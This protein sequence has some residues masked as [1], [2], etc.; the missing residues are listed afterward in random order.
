MINLFILLVT[1]TALFLGVGW[2]IG[3]FIGITLALLI[4]LIINFLS[5]WYS[6]R[7]ILKIYNAIPTKHIQVQKMVEKFAREAKIP[8]PKLYLIPTRPDIM[9]AF[10]TGRDPAHSAIAVTRGLLTLEDDEIEAVIAHEMGHIRNR[11]TLVSTVAAVLAG[12]VS[13]LAQIGYWS[14]FMGGKREG[15]NIF[16]MFMIMFFAPLAAVMIKL[17]ITRQREYGAD[18]M[19]VVL[20]KN[21]KSLVSALTK[22]SNATRE[23]ILRGPSATS[24][25]WIV[26]PFH[27]DWFTTLFST[28]PPIKERIKRIEEI[29]KLHI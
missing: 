20:T 22:I 11:D 4:A 6:D 1:L 9:N 28:H 26:N 8:V 10:A 18:Y 12:A 3:G 14:L 29:N 24:H 13:Y 25:I 23:H 15:G 27:K 17:A 19:G 16:A 2:V 7:I 5:Y 21:P